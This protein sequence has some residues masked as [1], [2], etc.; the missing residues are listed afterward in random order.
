M[1]MSKRYAKDLLFYVALW[2]TWTYLIG[3]FVERAA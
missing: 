3:T 2:G 1:R